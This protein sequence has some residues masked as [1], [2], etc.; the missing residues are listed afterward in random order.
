M[1]CCCGDGK[2]ARTERVWAAR[3]GRSKGRR[4]VRLSVFDGRGRLLGAW[5]LGL[6]AW[7]SG[8][9]ARRAGRIGSVNGAGRPRRTRL[10]ASAT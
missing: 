10:A 1:R 6:G 4:A 7:G 5:G 8:L 3:A 2:G 9:G